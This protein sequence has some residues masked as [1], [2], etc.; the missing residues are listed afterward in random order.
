MLHPARPEYYGVSVTFR[1]SSRIQRC[2]P[3]AQRTW[4]RQAQSLLLCRDQGRLA[5]SSQSHKK[6][7]TSRK[8]SSLHNRHLSTPPM[9]PSSRAAPVLLAPA[10]SRTRALR[11][12]LVRGRCLRHLLRYWDAAVP[13][14]SRVSV[15]C[16]P[17]SRT[18]TTRHHPLRDPTVAAA[19]APVAHALVSLKRTGWSAS[20]LPTPPTS[21]RRLR[22][23][24]ASPPAVAAAATF[25]PPASSLT[26]RKLSASSS[27]FSLTRAPWPQASRPIN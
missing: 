1:Q 26:I 6:C 23:R 3:E 25:V 9:A 27:S 24:A 8:L 15:T 4:R 14:L 17:L 20:G 5:V 11:S 19:A 21:S 10:C 2:L 22:R 16:V 18:S 12:A 13:L 7:F